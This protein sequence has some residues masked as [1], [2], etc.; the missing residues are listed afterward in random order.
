MSMTKVRLLSA[1]LLAVAIGVFGVAPAV[2]Q[3]DSASADA[4]AAAL[5]AK[6]L[7]FWESSFAEDGSYPSLQV[8]TSMSFANNA[9]DLPPEVDLPEFELKG[10]AN[11][12]SNR[13]VRYSITLAPH[14]ESRELTE[15][16]QR[17]YEVIDDLPRG[18]IIGGEFYWPTAI[19]S[20]W[21]YPPGFL[22]GW[23]K[24]NAFQQASERNRFDSLVRIL[25]QSASFEE[26]VTQIPGTD[27]Y[28]IDLRSLDLLSIPDAVSV[29]G[30][31]EIRGYETTHLSV[32]LPVLDAVANHASI[33]GEFLTVLRQ[34]GYVI[35]A[36][37]PSFIEFFTDPSYRMDV[38]V[39]I[40]DEGRIHRTSFDLSGVFADFFLGPYTEYFTEL[41]FEAAR[42]D[43]ELSF[44]SEFVY[45]DEDPVIEAPPASDVVAVDDADAYLDEADD[46]LHAELGDGAADDDGGLAND[47]GLAETGVNT[48][49][50]V[51]VGLSAVLAG[52]MVLGLR[53]RL[54]LRSPV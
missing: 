16:Q 31:S 3:D 23:L 25:N 32:D 45:L 43:F 8:Q 44:S 39:W 9:E 53:R 11:I 13:D 7:A 14:D 27:R 28:L 17:V 52:A 10:L 34:L 29:L 48:P 5:V 36:P 1:C 26:R 40:D 4:D 49:L 18:V 21:G 35:P 41:D 30:T 6:V 46:R 19:G 15:W 33:V 47:G 22:P 12:T 50:L 20:L 51:I 2:A 38:E 54:R 42:D 37:S 24:F